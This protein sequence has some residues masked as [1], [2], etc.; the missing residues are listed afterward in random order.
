MS[1]RRVTIRHAAKGPSKT[2]IAAA[3]GRTLYTSTRKVPDAPNP[4]GLLALR[5]S[6]NEKLGKRITKGWAKGMPLVT[7]TLEER[8]TCPDACAHWL[9]CYGNNMRFADRIMH[10]PALEAALEADVARLAAKYPAGFMVRLHVLGDFYSLAYVALW[11]RLMARHPALHVYG[12]TARTEGPMGAALAALGETCGR[13][14]MVRQS[15]HAGTMGAVRLA[16]HP[17]AVPCPEQTGKAP[18]CGA[19]GFCWTGSKAVGFLDH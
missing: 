2:A 5:M 9:D 7:L 12:Y 13:R 19:C 18:S 17:S 11:A 14:W 8:A 15:G 4:A 16:L 10:G 6:S 3:E 1:H